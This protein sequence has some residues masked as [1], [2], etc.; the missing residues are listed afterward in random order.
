MKKWNNPEFKVLCLSKTA[1]GPGDP[2][3]ADSE[4]YPVQDPDTGKMGWE[5]RFGT[6]SGGEDQT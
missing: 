1:F 4:L 2:T 6:L 5:Q 3:V